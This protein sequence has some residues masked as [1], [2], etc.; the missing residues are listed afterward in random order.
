M[1]PPPA[2]RGR[3]YHATAARFVVF[4]NTERD[5]DFVGKLAEQRAKESFAIMMPKPADQA[6]FVNK[7]E[8]AFK[9]ARAGAVSVLPTI[10]RDNEITLVSLVNLFPLRFVRLVGQ[11][12]SEYEKRVKEGGVRAALE[13]HIEDDGSHLPSLFIAGKDELAKDARPLLLLGRALGL[14]VE[15]PNAVTGK[16]SL[17][18]KQADGYGGIEPIALGSDLPAIAEI[19]EEKQVIALQKEVER[20]LSVGRGLSEADQSAALAVMNPIEKQ[21]ADSLGGDITH[22]KVAEWREARRRALRILRKE[23][24]P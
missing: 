22:P 2:W 12:R 3:N 14:I 1:N 8:V 10:G 5:R 17:I 6:D 11:L 24:V 4:D 19:I 13:I 23:D 20:A 15:N 21:V 7:L 18:L 9:N 16:T